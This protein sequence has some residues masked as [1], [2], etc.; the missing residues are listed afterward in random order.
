MENT[1]R[2]LYMDVNYVRNNIGYVVKGQCHL[3]KVDL[4]RRKLEVQME[5]TK[6]KLCME[7]KYF[8]KQ[9]TLC[10]ERIVSFGKD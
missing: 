5:N 4:F 6:G 9:F 2:K 3:L 1:E 10:G 7:V 8:Y